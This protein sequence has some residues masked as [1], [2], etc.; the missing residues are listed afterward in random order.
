M[1]KKGISEPVRSTEGET[2]TMLPVILVAVLAVAV[3][4]V[5]LKAIGVF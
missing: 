3:I 2:F 4:V 5:G 1:S